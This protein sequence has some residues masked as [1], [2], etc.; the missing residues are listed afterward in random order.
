MSPVLKDRR[1][2]SNISH[3]HGETFAVRKSALRQSWSCSSSELTAKSQTYSIFQILYPS[4]GLS[5]AVLVGP[6]Y[7]PGMAERK[8]VGRSVVQA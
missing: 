2:K 1:R 6:T 8:L 3:A 5:F 7:R 4:L